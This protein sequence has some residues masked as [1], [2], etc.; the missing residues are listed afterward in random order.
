ME[1]KLN[2][3]KKRLDRLEKDSLKY[4]GTNDWKNN[5]EKIA[6]LN[7]QIEQLTRENKPCT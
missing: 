6:K 4:T 2:K 5:H 7:R 1:N 3:L